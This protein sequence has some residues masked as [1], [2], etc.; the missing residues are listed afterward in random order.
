VLPA[1][2]NEDTIQRAIGSALD[3]RHLPIEV[4]VIDDMSV[5]STR[6]RVLELESDRV[7]VLDG[8]GR[9]VSAARNAGIRRA[10]GD[11][12]AF[13]DSDDYWGPE[14]LERARE[15]IGSAPDAVACFAAA[16]PV[17]DAGCVV[18]RHDIHDVVTLE[19]LAC[20]QV[21]PTTSATLVRREVLVACEGFFD[22]LRWAEDLDLWLRLAARGACV[23]V[24]RQSVFY[25]VHDERDRQ[26]PI[27]L[28]LELER[29]RELVVDRFAA[30][31]ARPRLVRRARAIMRAR[32]ARYWLRAGQSERARAA[33]RQSLR[34][35]PTFEGFVTLAVA[36]MPSACRDAL[37]HHRRRLRAGGTVRRA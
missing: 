26:R 17:D 28:L 36:T 27:E 3:Q 35:L 7:I 8:E 12:V 22:D 21:A 11:W 24:T 33:A 1:R 31:K 23:G 18:G 6:Q 25:V 19:E 9:G 15:R 5:D 34:V 29:D 4:I 2:D 30:S 20:G 32:T 10:R 14:H 37:V 16:T 13:L